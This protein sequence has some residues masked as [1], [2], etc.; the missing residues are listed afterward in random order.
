D[1]DR[2]KRPR[3]ARVAEELGDFVFVTSDNPRTENPASI[4]D[5]IVAGF[6]NSDA[7]TI[8]IEPDRKKAIELA[9]KSAGKD[10]IILIAGKGHEDYQIIGKQKFHF[11]DK[12]IAMECLK[13]KK[14]TET[15]QI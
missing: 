15:N 13:H 12:E 7:Q 8:A 14:Q 6:E 10:D 2:T 1:R 5:E 3:M 11:S 9:I 4:I